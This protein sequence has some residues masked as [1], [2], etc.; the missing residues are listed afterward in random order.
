M[1]MTRSE[2]MSRITAK[3]T[4]PEV[5]LRRA[6]WRRGIRGYRVHWRIQRCSPDIVFNK[7]KVAIF[8]DGCF[9]HGCP[10]HYVRPRPKKGSDFWA[11]KLKSNVE[12][13]VRQTAQL[14]NDGWTVLRYW[15]HEIEQNLDE[16]VE[17]IILSLNGEATELT[18]RYRVIRVE[19]ITES[20]GEEKWAMIDLL[21]E[22]PEKSELR[23]RSKKL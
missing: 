5:E 12:R 2:N 6:I 22:L 14:I 13:D 7:K 10:Q 16:V 11:N 23:H 9:W 20:N 1:A 15:E 21:G 19:E 8:I 18:Q 4:S 17:S 3:D